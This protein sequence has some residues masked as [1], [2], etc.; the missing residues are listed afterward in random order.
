[1]PPAGAKDEPF[2]PQGT[3][4]EAGEGQALPPRPKTPEEQLEQLAR[5]LA[6]AAAGD[7][8]E[9]LDL[10]EREAAVEDR[11][12]ILA[13]FLLDDL[14]RAQAVRNREIERLREIDQMKGRFINT[15][16]HELGTPLTPLKVQLHLLESG[17]LGPLAAPQARAVKILAR[18]L[19]RVITLVGD[20]L[21]ISRMDAGELKLRKVPLDIA[22]LVAETCDSFVDGAKQRGITLQQQAPEALFINGDGA[23]LGQVLYNLT[24]NALKFTP[25]G[26]TITVRARRR[27]NEALVQVQDTGIGLDSDDIARLAQPFVKLADAGPHGDPGTGLGLYITKGLVE[28]HGG[29]LWIESAGKGKGTTVSFAIPLL[30]DVP[31]PSSMPAF[32]ESTAPGAV[33]ATST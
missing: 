7:F 27:G 24:N 30:E 18:N 11:V 33:P 17:Q 32:Q 31:P 1:M 9:K 10:P 15:A 26:G 13:R 3:P 21:S 22:N 6:N 14:E 16:A 20:M 12:V 8:S 4:W 2:G 23:R 25:S 29:L 19:S 28:R 5:V